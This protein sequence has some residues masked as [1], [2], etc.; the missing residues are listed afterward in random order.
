MKAFL[1][2]AALLIVLCVAHAADTSSDDVPRLP[3]ITS[4]AFVCD[5]GTGIGGVEMVV[6]VVVTYS[7][8]AIVR[9]DAHHLHGFTVA[10][11]MQY[12]DSAKDPILYIAAC[13]KEQAQ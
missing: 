13:T 12:A 11:L 9:F 7:T 1:A 2:F 8:G 3:P 4:T 10:Q 6:A 5:I